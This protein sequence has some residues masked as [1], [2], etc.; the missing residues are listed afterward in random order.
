[1][2]LLSRSAPDPARPCLALSPSGSPYQDEPPPADLMNPHGAS[3]AGVS[4][5]AGQRVFHLPRFSAVKTNYD[6]VTTRGTT[7]RDARSYG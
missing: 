6:L 7:L 4:K 5:P 2:A 3:I 1:M